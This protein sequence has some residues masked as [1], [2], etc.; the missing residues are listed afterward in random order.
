MFRL[1][2]H[3][4]WNRF[5]FEFEVE[6][7]KDSKPGISRSEGPWLRSFGEVFVHGKCARPV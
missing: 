4:P 1:A 3:S 5:E 6:D 2:F 7:E